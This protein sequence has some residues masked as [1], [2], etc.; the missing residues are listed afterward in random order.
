M[1]KRNDNI[2]TM[3]EDSMKHWKK[4]SELLIP[5]FKGNGIVSL[6]I[7][8]NKSDL[9][10]LLALVL[11]QELTASDD[12]ELFNFGADDI[13]LVKLEVINNTS[14]KYWGKINWLSKPKNHNCYKSFQDPF[15]GLFKLEGNHVQLAQAMF[16]DY[17]QNDL[18][19]NNL[20]RSDINWM[21][22]L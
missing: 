15:F 13:V 21:Y 22:E 19:E 17:D 6:S 16:G 7:V 5:L 9:E 12:K 18:D 4:L 3:N 11:N 14:L 10:Y 1:E 20:I 2:D 8:D